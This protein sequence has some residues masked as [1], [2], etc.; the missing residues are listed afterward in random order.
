[1]KRFTIFVIAMIIAMACPVL[2]SAQNAD[3][4]QKMKIYPNPVQNYFQ[5]QNNDPEYEGATV[6]ML[7]L[8][9]RVVAV[10]KISGPNSWFPVVD[11]QSGTRLANASYVLRI[12]ST[13][14]KVK[15]QMVIISQ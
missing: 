9:K 11:Y 2:S 8:D 14:G 6:T 5:V 10:G 7:S 12:T 3:S 15:A 1:M 13:K 4:A